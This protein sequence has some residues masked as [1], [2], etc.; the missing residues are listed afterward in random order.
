[1]CLL[2]E[3]WIDKEWDS[4]RMGHCL[5]TEKNEAPARATLRTN[6]GH[7]RRGRGAATEDRGSRTATRVRCPRHANPRGPEGDGAF[8]GPGG[9]REKRGG[10]RQ[11]RGFSWRRRTQHSKPDA[12]H[13]RTAPR[14][15]RKRRIVPLKCA[16]CM[17]YGRTAPCSSLTNAGQSVFLL[18]PQRC[19]HLHVF[20]AGV[21]REIAFQNA[22]ITHTSI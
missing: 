14:T 16:A 3:E 8:L 10:C 21:E 11:T 13:G 1:M 22:G 12:A 6:L 4:R 5:G 20:T 9:A 7:V 19:Q 15:P 17:A 18:I 2:P